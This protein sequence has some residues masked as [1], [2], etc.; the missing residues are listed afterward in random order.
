MDGD[1]DLLIG[2]RHA[3]ACID[4]LQAALAADADRDMGAVMKACK[5]TRNPAFDPGSRL[6]QARRRAEKAAKSEK[7]AEKQRAWKRKAEEDRR[8][9]LGDSPVATKRPRN[10]S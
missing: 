4:T 1:G 10:S 8:A 3:H 7:E 9:L 5:A 2:V 6:Y